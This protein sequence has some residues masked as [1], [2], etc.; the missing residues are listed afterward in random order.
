MTIEEDESLDMLR[1][2]TDAAMQ[3]VQSEI[4]KKTVQN[5]SDLLLFFDCLMQDYIHNHMAMDIEQFRAVVFK[6]FMLR[7]QEDEEDDSFQVF[8]ERETPEMQIFENVCKSLYLMTQTYAVT[9]N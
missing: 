8:E 9:P 2:A 5:E 4:I 6:N 1:Q 7:Q 3:L